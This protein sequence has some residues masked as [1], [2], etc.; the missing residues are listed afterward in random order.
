M[1]VDD[2]A[3]VPLD[4]YDVIV[5][6]V[7]GIVVGLQTHSHVSVAVVIVVAVDVVAVVAKVES[8]DQIKIR[9]DLGSTDYIKYLHVFKNK[10]LLTLKVYQL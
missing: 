6:I 5:V 8:N 10:K 7:V 2:P 4:G 9:Y 3:V 1:E